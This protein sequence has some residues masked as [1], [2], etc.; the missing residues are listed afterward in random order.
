MRGRKKW[1]RTFDQGDQITDREVVAL[2]HRDGV[3][4]VVSC[5]FELLCRIKMSLSK[6]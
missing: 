5:V 2:R 4:V 1:E 3:V 6:L